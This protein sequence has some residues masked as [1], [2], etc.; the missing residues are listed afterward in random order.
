MFRSNY[1]QVYEVCNALLQI[2]HT[3]GVDSVTQFGQLRSDTVY[4]RK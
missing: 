3:Y 2:F 4:Y 1:E